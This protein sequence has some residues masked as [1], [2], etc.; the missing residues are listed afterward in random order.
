MMT[1]TTTPPERRPLSPLARCFRARAAGLRPDQKVWVDEWAEA[2]RTLPPDTPEPGPY[3]NARTPYLIDIQRTM[4]PASSYCEGWWQK[5]VQMGGS[6][7]GENMIA[8]WVCAAAGN[9]LVVFPTLD[10][11]KQWELTRF[12][13]MRATTR[14][15]RRRIRPAEEKGSDNTK[16]RKKYPGG[17]MRL[18]GANRVGALKSSTV[19]YVKFEIGRAHV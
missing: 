16:L 7:S 2:N 10:D 6:V 5:A 9:I 19:R 8:T 12:E 11:G 18:V 13:P 17:V 15:L 14:E 4:S 3:R 1:K